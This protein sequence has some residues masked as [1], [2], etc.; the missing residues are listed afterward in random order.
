M[1]TK[2][3]KKSSTPKTTTTADGK[4]VVSKV[5]RPHLASVPPK[6]ML[7]WYVPRKIQNR[8][9]YEVFQAAM[10]GKHNVLIEG[11]TGPGKTTA[12]MA[13]AARIGA[14]FYSIP[15]NIGVEPSQLFGK[16]VPDGNGSFIWV[17]GP[18]TEIARN[19]GVLLINEVNFMPE[20]V[21]TAIF[22]LLDG[23]REFSL[24][25]HKGE[26]VKAHDDLVIFAD[27]NPG[28]AG[29]RTL[30][31][32]F[33]NRFSIQLFWDYDPG[34]EKKLI[35]S[36]TLRKVMGNLRVQVEAGVFTTPVST[37][38]GQEFHTIAEALGYDFAVENFVTHFVADER[39]SVRKVFEA[40]SA[41]LIKEIAS[42]PP[43]PEELD[44]AR[45]NAKDGYVDPEW[46]VYGADWVWEED[47]D[48]MV[49]T[50]EESN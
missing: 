48:D 20:R 4:E 9:D 49:D 2:T 32:A 7:E 14:P 37:N 38:M 30:N 6:S 47:D 28:Y 25:D 21:A 26:T 22:G 13:F 19:G 23:R 12:V 34:V 3:L 46:G 35:K 41:N 29:T 27:M 15:S 17:D 1:T 39:E 10:D 45:Q 11:P 16:Y 18:V 33:R 44:D 5:S 8:M 50:D 42:K 36:D 24:L 31:Q 40:E 43:T